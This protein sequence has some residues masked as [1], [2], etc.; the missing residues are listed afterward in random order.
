MTQAGPR[1]RLPGLC[2][3]WTMSPLQLQATG[4]FGPW[5]LYL[6]EPV[7]RCFPASHLGAGR[8]KCDGGGGMHIVGLVLHRQ[9]SYS[10]PLLGQQPQIVANVSPVLQQQDP[11]MKGDDAA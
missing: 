3:L 8:K 10:C 6:K 4:S 7:Q 11:A 2:L 9:Q 1:S 5:L